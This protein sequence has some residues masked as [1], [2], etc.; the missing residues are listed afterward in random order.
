MEDE[1]AFKLE[2]LPHKSL[3]FLNDPNGASLKALLLGRGPS[4][5]LYDISKL[6]KLDIP[7]KWLEWNQIAHSRRDSMFLSFTILQ[8][9]VV[10]FRS[11][12][13]LLN[14]AFE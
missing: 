14:Q 13:S 1:H 9:V 8:V 2:A 6:I 4:K 10:F 11:T 7:Q 3:L 5:Q 12:K